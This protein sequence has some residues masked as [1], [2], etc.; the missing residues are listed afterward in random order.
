MDI[1]TIII[2]VTWAVTGFGGLTATVGLLGK[3][4]YSMCMVRIN[5]LEKRC[6]HLSRGCG[7]PICYWRSGAV[8]NEPTETT[9]TT[10]EKLC[11]S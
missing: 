9:E 4:V 10:P 3:L 11:Q 7:A 1:P 8:P 5:A 6:D 2:P